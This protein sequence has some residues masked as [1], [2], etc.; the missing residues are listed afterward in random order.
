MT[1]HVIYEKT[2]L[3]RLP[4]SSSPKKKAAVG[5]AIFKSLKLGRTKKPAASSRAVREGTCQDKGGSA[6]AASPQLAGGLAD[7]SNGAALGGHRGCGRERRE[8]PPPSPPS[9]PRFPKASEG[10]CASLRVPLDGTADPHQ[11]LTRA[12]QHPYTLCPNCFE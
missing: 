3:L 5:V 7:S 2:Q 11:P 10:S 8:A 9:P 1:I 12:G 6:A 4:L